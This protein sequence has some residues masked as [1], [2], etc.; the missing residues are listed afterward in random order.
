MNPPMLAIKPE[1][2]AETM[3][4]Q[5]HIGEG[6]FTANF[7]LLRQEITTPETANVLASIQEY[8]PTTF[9]HVLRVS[10][11]AAKMLEVFD[12]KVQPTQNETDS[13]MRAG[14]LHDTGKLDTSVEIWDKPGELTT[15]EFD[16]VKAHTSTGRERL[17]KI[18][19]F[20]G[21]EMLLNL[22]LLH[23]QVQHNAYVRDD[24]AE[25]II[26]DDAERFKTILTLFAMADQTEAMTSDREYV[27]NQDLTKEDVVKRLK[28]N[29]AA[30]GA[31]KE[32][33]DRIA[34]EPF[35]WDRELHQSYVDTLESDFNST[36]STPSRHL[37]LV[38]VDTPN[39]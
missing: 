22:T 28:E 36:K 12:D 32:I 10:V 16:K 4:Y 35:F 7:A 31:S 3:P 9:K 18:E 14:L 8:H 19:T 17:A 26:G 20:A 5:E 1:T 24:V 27:K 39:Q 38:G 21:D 15:E 25:W 34:E 6:E 37:K 23:H 30:F 11:F 2:S 13:I 29:L 33:A